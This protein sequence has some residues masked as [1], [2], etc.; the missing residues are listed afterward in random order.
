[1]QNYSIGWNSKY[2]IFI[3]FI[4]LLCRK[5]LLWLLSGGH[6]CQTLERSW[7][8]ICGPFHQDFPLGGFV[9]EPFWNLQCYMESFHFPYRSWTPSLQLSSTISLNSKRFCPHIQCHY[10]KTWEGHDPL[11]KKTVAPWT[12]T[13]THTLTSDSVSERV[14]CCLFSTGLKVNTVGGY[15]NTHIHT[16]STSSPWVHEM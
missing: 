12:Y 13:L 5:Q 16:R 4:L 8:T 7:K 1:M 9:F 11:E 6:Q 10:I 2:P 14:Q 15:T 3:I